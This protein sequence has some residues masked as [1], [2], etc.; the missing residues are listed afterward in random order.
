[1]IAVLVWFVVCSNSYNY[2]LLS[3][4]MWSGWVLVYW[5]LLS[6]IETSF[7]DSTHTHTYIYIYAHWANPV[8]ASALG[9]RY[10]PTPK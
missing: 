1:M 8:M 9:G 4:S 5:F 3:L 7:V 10:P 2:A 6:E